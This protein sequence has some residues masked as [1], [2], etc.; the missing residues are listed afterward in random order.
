MKR[1]FE[2]LPSSHREQKPWQKQNS[3]QSSENSLKLNRQ[4]MESIAKDR[5]LQEKNVKF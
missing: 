1:E 4:C 5:I 3:P 2:S